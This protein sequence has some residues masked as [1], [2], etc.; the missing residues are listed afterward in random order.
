MASRA[1]VALA[2]GL[3]AAC[4]SVDEALLRARDAGGQRDG[5]GGGSG[6]PGTDGGGGNGMGGAGSGASGGTGG[7]IGGEGGAGGMGAGAGGAGGT[8]A[9][10]AG[11]TPNPDPTDEV[12]P[13]IC[14]ETCN[15]EDDDCDRRIDEGGGALCALAHA[16]AACVNGACVISAC[17]DARRDCNGEV[18]DGCEV[19]ED[20]PDHCG[21]CGRAC[22]L[23][24]AKET[25]V[26]DE[27]EVASCENGWADCDVDPLD[28]ETP[29]NTADDCAGC[30]LACDAL[31]HAASVSCASGS[32]EVVDCAGNYG[33]CD[34]AGNNGCEQELNTLAHC[35]ECDEPCALNGGVNDCATGLCKVT[36]CNLGFAQCDGN[37]VNGCERLNTAT[38]CGACGTPCSPGALDHVVAADCASGACAIT[39]EDGWGDCDGM[40]ENGCETETRSLVH[41][42]ECDEACAIPGAVAECTTGACTFVRCQD[43]LGDCNSDL[44]LDG[45][46]QPLN[47]DQFCGDCAT[48]CGATSDPICSGGQCADVACPAGTADC[49]QD[50]LPCEIDTDGDEAN[51][52]ACGNLC[53]FDPGTTHASGLTC[54]SGACQPNCDAT[55]DDCDNNYRNG[56]ETSLRTT[57]DCNGCGVG[58][59]IAN[60]T[61]T[62]VTGQ[63][64]VQTCATDFDDCN[65]DQTSCETPLN[66]TLNCGACGAMCN[67]ANAI[68]SCAGTPGTRVCQIAGCSESYYKDCDTTH[69]TGCEIDT[70]TATA[71]CGAC[72]NNCVTKPHVV[73]ASCAASACV[74]DQCEFG[75][76]DC[77]TGAGCETSVNT[78]QR[79][80]ACNIDCDATLANTASTTCNG[81]NLTCAV[82]TCD[83]GY[84]NCDM[85]HATGCE[86]SLYTTLNCGGCASLG[87]NETCAGLSHVAASSCGAGDCVIDGCDSG[88]ANCDGVV[89]NGCEHDVATNG[90]CLPDPS[91]TKLTYGDSTYFVCTAQKTWTDARTACL[92]QTRGDLVAIEGSA[93]ND[94]VVAS[95]ATNVS[96]GASDAAIEGLWA[97]SFNGTPFWRGTSTGSALL[98]RYANWSTGEPGDSGGEDCAELRKL[99][100]KWNDVACAGTR[101]FVCE[102][103]PDRCPADAAKVDPGQC[104]CG[105]PDADADADGFAA[106]AD[107]CESDATKQ[108]PGMCGCGIPDGDTDSDGFADCVEECDSDPLKQDPGDC[109]CNMPDTDAD[110]DGFAQ[111]MESCDADPDKQD[112]GTCGCNYAEADADA[113]LTLDCDD[114]CPWDA[115]RT[116]APCTGCWGDVSNFTPTDAA[117]DFSRN[118]F[119]DCNPTIDTSLAPAAM[120]TGWCG[121]QPTPVVQTQAMGGPQIVVLPMQSFVL[122]P[123]RTLALRGNKP[124]VFAV[125]GDA[126]IAGTIDAGATLATAGPGGNVGCTVGQGIGQ[127]G[128]DGVIDSGTSGPGGGGGAGGGFGAGG[129]GGGTTD[130][131]QDSLGGPPSSAEG[132]ANLVPL[133]GGCQGGRGG[134]GR[135]PSTAYG[136]GGGGAVQITAVGRLRITGI[137]SAPG[138]GGVNGG[139]G[140][141]GGGGGSGGGILLEAGTLDTGTATLLANGGG[142]AAGNPYANTNG[143]DGVNGALTSSSAAAGGV[144]DNS[145]GNGGTGGTATLAAGNGANATGP[146]GSRG[147]GGGGGGRGRIHQRTLT[148][149]GQCWQTPGFASAVDTNTVSFTG[150][151]TVTLNAACGG[152]TTTLD[153]GDTNGTPVFTNWCGGP[154]PTQVLNQAGAKQALVVKLAGL[155][156]AAGQTLRIKGKRPVIVLVDGAVLVDGIVD[157]SGRVAATEAGPGGGEDCGAAPGAPVGCQHTGAVTSGARTYYFCTNSVTWTVARDN[158]AAGGGSLVALNDA[159]ENATVWS[160]SSARFGSDA[161]TAGNSLTTQ[162]VWNWAS[163]GNNDAGGGIAPAFW[164]SGEPNN[165][166]TEKCITLRD[167]AANWNNWGCGNNAPWIC[168][169]SASTGVGVMGTS[170]GAVDNGAGGGGGGGQALAGGAGARG[171]DQSYMGGPGGAADGSTT[172]LVGG[173]AGGQGGRSNVPG[174]GGAGGAAGGGLQISSSGALQVTASGR[175]S[176]SGGGGAKASGQECGGGGGG[177]A[178]TLLVEGGPLTLD[179]SSVLSANGGGG[180]GGND[181]TNVNSASGADGAV[182][183]AAGGGGGAAATGSVGA[184]AVGGVCAYV[185][186]AWQP[187]V[188]PASATATTAA[189][190]G[191]GGGGGS[192]GRVVVHPHP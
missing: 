134:Q 104:G 142:G 92:S 5:D 52:G 122:Q 58:C 89:A 39:C 160:T 124:V 106:C 17:L 179:P 166:S 87:Q 146:Y 117:L 159:S 41:C 43:G 68:A 101:A 33:D 103:I 6:T 192:F 181:I 9:P 67:L 136:G 120:L 51:C 27:C 8:P 102:V 157:A 139:E 7:T 114:A 26:A 97:W 132:T 35:G 19:A 100:G 20:D 72:N 61:A 176:V 48:D 125:R 96:I 50:G 70:R 189:G 121:E 21:T 1:W 147:G 38:D 156:V 169:F 75:W 22:D 112:P 177:S 2:L 32:C 162:G 164:N 155:T 90:P 126:Q 119:L 170:S 118:V 133:R 151:P 85:S 24:H 138:G 84:G 56:C 46:E 141:G 158:C 129:G 149:G 94:F 63:C 53:A 131:N 150:A 152:T 86:T 14:P 16:T 49:A 98:G 29:T 172:P 59:A 34:D 57:T 130:D 36:G 135:D 163:G 23:L 31:D 64:R 25:C 165:L 145:S 82:A 128:E 115:S 107:L 47:V 4:S 45:C 111:C 185:S 154:P 79:C 91:C 161:W 171:D 99:D 80:G 40:P 123:G 116:A 182:T 108:A 76:G 73:A 12:C 65:V 148:G 153:S 77:N 143:T 71:H 190:D 37:P 69:A 144:G 173:C 174:L 93:E 42:G 180:G 13:E 83:P 127:Q 110:G 186:G 66:T 74:F 168:E 88:W 54:A 178:G 109:G 78:V 140:N 191:G 11:C 105:V 15:D 167:S 62:C 183:A 137:V 44:A 175:I 28:C 10:G 18:P 55:Y 184:G 113:D 3:F 188:A 187:L 30:G 60:A 81:V 95:V